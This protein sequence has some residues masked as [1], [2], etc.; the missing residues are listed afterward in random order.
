MAYD[1]AEA[2]TRDWIRGLIGDTA[3]TPIILDATYDSV[4]DRYPISGYAVAELALRMARYW[5]GQ[6]NQMAATGD[7]SIGYG[8]NRVAALHKIAADW[9]AT[10]DAEAR[11]AGLGQVIAIESDYLTGYDTGDYAHG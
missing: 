8:A 10:A 11:R 2:T 3:A 4:I 5:E 6:P 9:K 7:G 1:P